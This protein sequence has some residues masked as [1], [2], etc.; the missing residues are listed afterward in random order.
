MTKFDFHFLTAF[1]TYFTNEIPKRDNIFALH[2]KENLQNLI[3]LCD[4]VLEKYED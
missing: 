1:Y 3:K 4:E 2:L